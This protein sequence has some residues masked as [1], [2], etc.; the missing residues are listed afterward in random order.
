MHLSAI[1]EMAEKYWLEIP[2]HFPF[3]KL[4]AFIIMP[5]HVHGIIILNKLNNE[6]DQTKNKFGPQSKNLGSIIRGYKIGVVINARKVDSSFGWQPRYYDNIIHNEKS[7]HKISDYINRN[8]E[9]W[10]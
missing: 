3:V 9:Q 2:K 1:G 8:P 6:G 10:T 5:N 4:G 7:Y